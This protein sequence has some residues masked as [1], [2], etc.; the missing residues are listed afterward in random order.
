MVLG[1]GIHASCP[2]TLAV[3]TGTLDEGEDR[4]VEVGRTDQDDYDNACDWTDARL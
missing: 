2:V 4:E 1:G 3:G